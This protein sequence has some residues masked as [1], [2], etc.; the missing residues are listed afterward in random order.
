MDDDEA[1]L[2]CRWSWS[3]VVLVLAQ[4]FLVVDTID[5]ALDRTRIFTL[6]QSPGLRLPATADYCPHPRSCTLHRS[7][8]HRR[9]WPDSTTRDSLGS[10]RFPTLVTLTY[11]HVYQPYMLLPVPP[12]T[13]SAFFP[14]L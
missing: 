5:D 8:H 4:C 3:N 10:F 11:L 1:K 2:E 7:A 6:V 14:H 12:L 13:S 9:T